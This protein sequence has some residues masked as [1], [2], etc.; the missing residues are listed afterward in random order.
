MCFKE[1]QTIEMEKNIGLIITVSLF[2]IFCNSEKYEM[3]KGGMKYKMYFDSTGENA[4]VGDK[5]IFH[6]IHSTSKDS[7]IVNTWESN[8]IMELIV[9]QP[10]G[11][12]D[13]MEGL[14]MMSEGDSALFLLNSDVLYQN[15]IDLIDTTIYKRGSYTKYA[16]KVFK[17]IP[18]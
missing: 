14:M 12:Q 2:S 6:L 9:E 1:N 16:I 13:L 15:P 8:T 4:K 11:S 5:V 17:I 10:N 3:T 7:I 18:P